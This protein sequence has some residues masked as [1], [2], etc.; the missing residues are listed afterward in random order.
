MQP[1]ISLMGLHLRCR[2]WIAEMNADITVLRIF[3]DYI[4]EMASKK[5]GP[6]V[7]AGIK[8]FQST[9]EQFRRD[10]DELR[11]EFHLLKMQLAA[12][13]REGKTINDVT[14][15]KDHQETLRK[16]YTSYR[17]DF[18]TVKYEFDVFENKWLS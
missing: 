18:D 5:T 14:G 1:E 7:K 9:F 6:E 15:L 16:R 8:H 11:H 3:N 17:K 10:S 2:L 12:L 4:D 13:S